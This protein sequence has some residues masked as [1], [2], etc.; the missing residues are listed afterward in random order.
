MKLSEEHHEP[1]EP[2]PKWLAPITTQ[3][4][5]DFSDNDLRLGSV[6]WYKGRVFT[7]M[8]LQFLKDNKIEGIM[9]IVQ[10][11]VVPEFKTVISRKL[12][13]KSIYIGSANMEGI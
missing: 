11:N 6:F 1:A 9:C 12:I 4:G 8:D 13:N 2:K 10:G 3:K 7:L 5:N